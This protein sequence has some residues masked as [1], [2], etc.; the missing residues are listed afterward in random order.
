MRLSKAARAAGKYHYNYNIVDSKAH[1]TRIIKLNDTQ[2]KIIRYYKNGRI[3]TAGDYNEMPMEM[4]GKASGTE[5]IMEYSTE[6]GSKFGLHTWYHKNGQMF[7][8]VEYTDGIENMSDVPICHDN[9]KLMETGDIV[10]GRRV[11]KWTYYT[12]RGKIA[13]YEY[14][15]EDGSTIEVPE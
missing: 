1:K 14:Y 2:I 5:R 3:K 10:M 6:V 7:K 4:R 12:K 9:G 11:G 13:F 15:T 8:C